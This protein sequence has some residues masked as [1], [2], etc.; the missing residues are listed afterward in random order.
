M[1]TIVLKKKKKIKF[2]LKAF[3]IAIAAILITVAIVLLWINFEPVYEYYQIDN[4]NIYTSLGYSTDKQL[5][6]RAFKQE[7]ENTYKQNL[8]IV[9]FNLKS[10][11]SYKLTIVRRG[12]AN[13]DAVQEKI[14]KQVYIKVYAKVLQ[15]E[16][17][18]YYLQTAKAHNTLSSMK[19]VNPKLKTEFLLGTYID[20]DLLMSEEEIKNFLANYEKKF[21]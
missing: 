2:K 3:F 18:T 11:V 5:I 1:E 6:Y 19:E 12:S 16:G 10:Y 21:A 17:K 9:D 4:N 13:N 7:F 15:Y 20:R 8:Q 14:A